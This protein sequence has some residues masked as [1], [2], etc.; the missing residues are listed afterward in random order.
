MHWIG[1]WSDPGTLTLK[2][3]PH[4]A[5]GRAAASIVNFKLIVFAEDL[6]NPRPVVL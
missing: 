2:A 1:P 5:S 6:Q 3:C 4:V